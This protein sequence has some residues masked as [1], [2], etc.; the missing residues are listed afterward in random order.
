V[1]TGLP[2]NGAGMSTTATPDAT[3]ATSSQAALAP[4]VASLPS[5]VRA[6]VAIVIAAYGEAGS[7]GNVVRELRAQYPR[8]LV[9]DD[10]SAD[11]TADEARR[12]G[13]IVLCHY[14]NRGQGAA[15]QTG[16]SYALA[17]GAEYLVTFDADGQHDMNDLP[18]LI[19]P[20]VRGEVEICLGSR[21]LENPPQMPILRR[22]V[23][24]LAVLFT[25]LTSRVR[26]TDAHNGL[27]A[28]TRRAA[29]GI[30]IQLDRMA[31]ASEIVDQFHAS[32]LP[33]REIP[34]RVRYTEYSLNK[35]QRNS[36]AFKVAF[37]YLMGRLTR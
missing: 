3:S 36:A 18:A 1:S 13:A 25:R 2:D 16:I 23:I 24:K 28:F 26:L 15:L 29:L 8:V 27:R 10:G 7:I 9:V 30:D 35:G 5:E 11:T 17:L 37:D 33:Y 19:S 21:F 6:K 4:A 20:L 12:A 22:V 32:G 14:V 31:H 34:V